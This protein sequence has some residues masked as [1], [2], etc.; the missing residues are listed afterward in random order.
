MLI[1]LPLVDDPLDVSDGLEGFSCAWA[2]GN[3]TPRS[4]RI[5]LAGI[6]FSSHE[7]P[8]PVVAHRR[9]LF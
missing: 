3:I 9:V 5:V 1:A 7:P 6:A 2:V 8:G 4:D